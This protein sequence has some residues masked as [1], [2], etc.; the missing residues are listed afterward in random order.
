M[1][2]VLVVILVVLC[3]LDIFCG[4][5]ILAF[6]RSCVCGYVVY[7]GYSDFV[8]I[9]DFDYLILFCVYGFAFLGKWF[10]FVGDCILLGCW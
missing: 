4:V 1:L 2:F 10:G 9:A 5:L 7:L 3:Y 6:E 8:D